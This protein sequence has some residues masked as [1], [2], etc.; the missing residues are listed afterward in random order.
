MRHR[1]PGIVP[2]FVPLLAWLP[3]LAGALAAAVPEPL[4][5]LTLDQALDL[6]ERHHPRLAEARAEVEAAAGRAEDA[7]KLPNPEAIIRAEQAPL[8]DYPA[9]DRQYVAGFGQTVPLG[10]RLA[11]AR[12]AER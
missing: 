5:S 10:R 7:G 9:P 4:D 3:L 8:R 11:R 12:E 2:P 6:A 1:L